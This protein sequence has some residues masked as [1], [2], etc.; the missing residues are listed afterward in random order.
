MQ[1]S[2]TVTDVKV[3]RSSNGGG[4]VFFGVLSGTLE[5]DPSSEPRCNRRR[6]RATRAVQACCC[7]ALRRQAHDIALPDQKV[8]AFLAVTVS[9]FDEHVARAERQNFAR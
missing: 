9:A 2:V 6:Q 8:D 5:I 1:R 3:P 4:D 7:N